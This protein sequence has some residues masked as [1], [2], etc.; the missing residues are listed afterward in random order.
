MEDFNTKCYVMNNEEKLFQLKQSLETLFLLM[1]KTRTTKFKVRMFYHLQKLFWE[2]FVRG[3][4]GLGVMSGG[5]CPGIF[6]LIPFAVTDM[7]SVT[8]FVLKIR[9]AVSM[10]MNALK[11]ANNIKLF[12]VSCKS[13][14]EIRKTAL[15][16]LLISCLLLKFA[17]F[18][19]RT[20]FIASETGA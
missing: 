11:R 14:S 15:T 13:A 17:V 12:V 7:P 20:I 5:F 1:K 19:E 18:G 4:F 9:N 3:G 10:S 2:V 8:S 6:V 16:L